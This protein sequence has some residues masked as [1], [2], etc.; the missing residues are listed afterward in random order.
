MNR[1][2][3]IPKDFDEVTRLKILTGIFGVHT[4]HDYDH[5]VPV[6]ETH[7]VALDVM[8]GYMRKGEDLPIVLSS[9]PNLEQVVQL[10]ELGIE[11]VETENPNT[12]NKSFRF[13]KLEAV[14]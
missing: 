12:G 10:E 14:M 7:A 4:N 2:I 9:P 5:G 11:I 6:P 3:I 13:S 1:T 8:L